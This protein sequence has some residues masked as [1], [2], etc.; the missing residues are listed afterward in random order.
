VDDLR[1]LVT[2]A[3][4]TEAAHERN[5]EASESFTLALRLQ[6]DGLVTAGRLTRVPGL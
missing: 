4:F 6:F 2:S 3:N 1:A 5:I